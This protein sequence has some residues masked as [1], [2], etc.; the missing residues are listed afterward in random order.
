MLFAKPPL[1][2]LFAVFPVA[3][4]PEQV[5]FAKP[6]L[7]QLFAVF[8]V[9]VHPEQMLYAKPPLTQLFAVLFVID[10]LVD[11]V[12]NP[13]P[14]FWNVHPTIILVWALDTVLSVVL[15]VDSKTITELPKKDTI[16][17][18]GRLAVG[19]D[20]LNVIPG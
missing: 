15:C 11:T 7:L 3:V 6:P 9:A 5:L 13:F 16:V 12:A 1:L 10:Q 8:P 17:P 18:T 14:R 4:H 20:D 19:T 2:Q